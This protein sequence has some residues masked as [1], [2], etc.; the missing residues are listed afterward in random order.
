MWWYHLEYTY[1]EDSESYLGDIQLNNLTQDDRKE[2][3][4]GIF[5]SK[6]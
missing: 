1:S 2:L 6:S 4:K 3:K 5:L